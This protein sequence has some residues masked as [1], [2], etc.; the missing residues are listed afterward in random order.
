MATGF[1][2]LPPFDLLDPAG[3]Y[4]FLPDL[5]SKPTVYGIVLLYD[6][7]TDANGVDLVNHIPN[8]GP[9]WQN[10][11]QMQIQSNAATEST[12]GNPACERDAGQANVVIDTTI[13]LNATSGCSVELWARDSNTANNI[14]F[15]LSIT[16]PALNIYTKIANAFTLIGS[17]TI[18]YTTNTPVTSQIVLNGSGLN[19]NL[20]GTYVLSVTSTFNQTATRIGVGGSKGNNVTTIDN[21]K[22]RSFPLLGPPAWIVPT[23]IGNGSPFEMLQMLQSPG[24]ST[25]ETL[26]TVY[27]PA[28]GTVR[29]PSLAFSSATYWIV[30][31][32]GG[33]GSSTSF[34][35]ASGA[36]L[37][38]FTTVTQVDCSAVTGI[39]HAWGPK[40]FQ[41]VDASWHV[42][43]AIST[44]G[45][46]N[47]QIYELHPTNAGR[48]TWSVPVVLTGTNLQANIIDWFQF[49]NTAQS[50][51]MAF[52]KDE[53]AKYVCRAT[54]ASSF[55]GWTMDKSGDWAGW[56]HDLWEGC[57][58]VHMG[59][60]H[61]RLYVDGYQSG[62]M[63]L[64]YDDSFDGGNM[65]TGTM[66]PIVSPWSTPRNGVVTQ[67]GNP[68]VVS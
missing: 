51:Y 11:G 56:G 30:H 24:G 66:T 38:A 59:G 67:Y 23:F 4:S 13:N 50:K 8:V 63:G 37:A 12:T 7:F 19:F 16:G 22:V 52:F 44:S 1:E 46:T 53:T 27:V 68:G 64:H 61:Y 15:Q 34:E 17:E 45:D 36:T 42:L 14:E 49:Y 10:S 29:D 26:P 39:V 6:T 35:L 62:S 31:T 41:D 48:T 2:F 60:L 57:S 65:F 28:M 43:V 55:S 58:V 54:S 3:S 9:A 20:A 18:A 33:A 5:W 21:H 40:W 47:N 25:F 32:S